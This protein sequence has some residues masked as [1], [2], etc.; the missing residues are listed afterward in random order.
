[1]QRGEKFKES[2]ARPKIE[3]QIERSMVLSWLEGYATV[4]LVDEKEFDPIEELGATP[5]ELAATLKA[6]EAA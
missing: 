3:A 5:E 6:D 4:T 2:E 1:V